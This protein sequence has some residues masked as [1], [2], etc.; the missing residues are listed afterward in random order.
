MTDSF[1]VE[2]KETPVVAEDLKALQVPL[3]M[4]FNWGLVGGISAGVVA[5][6]SVLAFL[7]LRRRRA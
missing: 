2:E 7:L 1:A 5:L 6:L 3:G 4:P